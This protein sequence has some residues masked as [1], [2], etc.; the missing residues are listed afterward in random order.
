MGDSRVHLLDRRVGSESLIDHLVP[1]RKK[2]VPISRRMRTNKTLST[3]P[4][5]WKTSKRNSIG[6]FIITSSLVWQEGFTH[7]A[8]LLYKP[9]NNPTLRRIKKLTPSNF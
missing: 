1:R 7:H 4:F 9:H 8:I 3:I 5:K 6:A 2:F